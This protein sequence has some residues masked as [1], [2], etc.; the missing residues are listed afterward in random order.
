MEQLRSI[1]PT[2]LSVGF[3]RTVADVA[4]VLGSLLALTLALILWAKFA[5]RHRRRRS[6]YPRLANPS[7]EVVTPAKTEEE[8]DPEVESEHRQHQRRRF[9]HRR[10]EHRLRNPTLAETGGL[11]APRSDEPK[12]PPQ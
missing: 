9:R 12:P 6:T 5:R 7:A 4:L 2:S 1:Q 8:H 10:R 11:P 3:R